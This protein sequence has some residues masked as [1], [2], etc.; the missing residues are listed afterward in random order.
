[1]GHYA[2][3]HPF[4]YTKF[5]Y[6]EGYAASEYT[7]FFF[8]SVLQSH[9]SRPKHIL[10]LVRLLSIRPSSKTGS[11]ATEKPCDVGYP[12]VYVFLLMVNE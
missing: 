1:M 2:T 10:K 3:D 11:K 7:Q 9:R 5:N 6:F 4:P 8:L 12:S